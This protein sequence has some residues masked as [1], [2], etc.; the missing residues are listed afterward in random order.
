MIT[1]HLRRHSFVVSDGKGGKKLSPYGEKWAHIVG[2][3]YLLTC[4]THLLSGNTS[5]TQTTLELMGSNQ[6]KTQRQ[7][8]D[9]LCHRRANLWDLYLVRHGSL[10]YDSP[11]VLE[12]ALR[13]REQFLTFIQ[14]LDGDATVLAVGEANLL[15]T[16]V[17]AITGR[18]IKKPFRECEGATLIRRMNGGWELAKEIRVDHD[19]AFVW[20]VKQHEKLNGRREKSYRHIVTF[21][22]L[23]NQLQALKQEHLEIQRDAVATTQNSVRIRRDAGSKP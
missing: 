18:M 8:Q 20:L 4:F 2:D 23:T 1:I 3:F 14:T 13:M 7:E 22:D 5:H 16:L 10:D 9:F 12:E 17:F 15:E 6:L 19:E 21:F 11:L